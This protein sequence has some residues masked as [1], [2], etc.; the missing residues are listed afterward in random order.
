MDVA[1]RCPQCGAIV[2]TACPE[3]G[4]RVRGDYDSPGV[5]A[6]GFPY[7]PPKFCDECGAPFPW[8]G[9]EE[10]LYELENVMEQEPGLD[11][12]TKLWLREQIAHLHDIEAMDPKAQR[13]VW[14]P[15]KDHAEVL[16]NN[17]AAQ[18]IMGT[19]MSEAVKRALK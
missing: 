12:A 17:P 6:L 13:D 1:K 15:I 10:R 9:R 18:K 4:T 8:V 19:L 16:W 5:V 2:L 7:D 3:C 14:Q 11:E